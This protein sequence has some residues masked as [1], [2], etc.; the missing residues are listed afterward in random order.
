[1][2]SRGSQILPVAPGTL[3]MLL[4]SAVILLLAAVGGGLNLVEGLSSGKARPV[5]SNG[6]PI[7]RPNSM[8]R[9]AAP[10][11][12]GRAEGH[13]NRVDIVDTLSR[14]KA[15]PLQMMRAVSRALERY[16]NC[17]SKASTGWRTDP[18]AA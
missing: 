11:D 6:P 12:P 16:P 5:P 8:R 7:T 2:P 1:M 13:Q 9:R 18:N 4:G 15:T 10:G 17:R 3:G 14:Y